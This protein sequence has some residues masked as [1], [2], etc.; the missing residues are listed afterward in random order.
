MTERDI[1]TGEPLT[2]AAAERPVSL[3]DL[4]HRAVLRHP[5]REALRWK[6]RDAGGWTSRTYRELWD[7]VELTSLGLAALGMRAGDRAVI[8]SRSRAEW[9]VA[10]MA[11]MALGAVTCPIFSG[12]KPDKVEF[13]VRNVDARFVFVESAQQA[14][15]LRT[16]ATA[17]RVVV[18]DEKSTQHD[19]VIPFAQLA[20]RS[21]PSASA[22]T[23]WQEGWAAIGRDTVA[24]VVHTSGTSG[25]PKGVVLTHGNVIHNYEVARQ[26][27][28]FSKD[29]LALSVLPLSHMLERAAGMYVPLGLGAAV[30]F[31]EPVMERWASNLAEVRPTVMVAIPLFFQ[32]I[33]QRVVTEIG[34][35]AGWK[36]RAFAWA[37]Q[38]GARRYAN[39][40][41]GRGDS[42]WLRI[43]LAIAQRLV[44]API[45]A[46]TGGRLRFFCSGGA[47]LSREVGEFFYAMDMLILEGYGLSETG[48]LLT[49]TRPE[50]FKFGT[51]G[52]PIP[53]T[54]IRIERTSGEV[55][56]RG[57]QVMRGYL[58]AADET[59]QAIDADGWFHT[60]DIGEFDEAGRLSITDRI[61]NLIVLDNGKKVSPTPMELALVSS[62]YIAE[63]VLIGDGQASTGALVVPDYARVRAWGREGGLDLADAEAAAIHPEVQTL[64][65]D[66]SRRLLRDFAAYERPR[67]VALLPRELSED[68]G[69]V[70]GALRK[71]K[72]RVIVANWPDHVARLF[73]PQRIGSG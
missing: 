17:P 39:H 30:A 8:L 71:P 29:D 36:Q 24:T 34:R 66:E 19:D 22:R 16:N 5:N 60:G 41:A 49:I 7:W 54:Q 67:K 48:P 43:S 1:H 26:I 55:L 45:K 58:N 38:L 72:R 37:T 50:S 56:A 44:F 28:P 63:A 6:D 59:A 25:E 40:L 35:Q 27:L 68:E 23:A 46:R 65:E 42:P 20:S 51:V 73:Q 14:A 11:S 64:I 52:E 32:R 31:A 57:P 10:D 15:K 9:V 12:E 47:P 69:E 2:L 3:V 62:P 13:M 4:V 53:E 70:T 33:H 21:G 61:K 18:F